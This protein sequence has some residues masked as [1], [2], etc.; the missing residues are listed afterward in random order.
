MK[1]GILERWNI[2]MMVQ[3]WSLFFIPLFQLFHHS[4]FPLILSSPYRLLD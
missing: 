1:N 3:S 4:N 2:G